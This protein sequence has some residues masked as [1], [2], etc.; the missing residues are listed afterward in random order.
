[1]DFASA[2]AF[3]AL[4]TAI[5]EEMP[6]HRPKRKQQHFALVGERGGICAEDRKIHTAGNWTHPKRQEMSAAHTVISDLLRPPSMR[7]SS[8][9]IC[10]F[11]FCRAASYAA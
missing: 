2:A 5:A 6:G 1:V 3:I 7:I 10:T 9:F 11:R 8:T 4:E